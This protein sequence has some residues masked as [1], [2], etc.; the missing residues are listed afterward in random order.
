MDTE[1]TFEVYLLDK[2]IDRQKFQEAEPERFKEW[3]SVFQ[4]VSPDSFTMQKKF[5]INPIRRKYLIDL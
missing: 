3:E 5:L 4:K 1:M 2:K